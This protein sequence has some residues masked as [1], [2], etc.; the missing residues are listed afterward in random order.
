MAPQQQQN[1]TPLADVNEAHQCMSTYMAFTMG[2]IPATQ[3][4]AQRAGLPFGV[5]VHPLAEG[6]GTMRGN[7]PIVDFGTA[8]VIRCKKCRAYINPFAKFVDGGKRW[9]CNLCTYV[10]D[11]PPQYFQPTDGDGNRI[12]VAQRPELSTG[13]VEFIAPAEYTVRAPQ[14]PVYVFVLDVSWAAISNGVLAAACQTIKANLDQLPGGERTQVGFITFDSAVHFFSLRSGLRAPQMLVVSDVDELFLPIPDELLVNLH[15]GRALVD[16]LLDALPNMFP[17]NRGP[18]SCLGPALQAAYNIMQHIGGKMLVFQSTLPSHGAGKLK[19]RELPKMVGS[20]KEHVL[21]AP[22][23]GEDGNFYRTKAADFSRQQIS[24]DMFLFSHAYT[25]VA[26]LG[27]LSR[28]T[29]GQVYH[30]PGFTSGSDGERF[31]RDLARNLTRTTGFEAVMR[32]RTS[33]GLNVT[34]FYGNFFIRGTDLLALPNVTADTAFN[35]ELVHEEALQPG[36]VITIQAALLYTTST[37]ERRICV[38]TLAKPVTTSMSDLFRGL[39]VHTVT[40]MMAK[41]ALDQ[42]LRTGIPMARRHLHKTVVD[43][44]R[45]YRL[46][47]SGNP[48]PASL[49]AAAG[50]N[51]SHMPS[52]THHMSAPGQTASSSDLSTM[53]PECLQLL[54]LYSMGL[55]KCTL[56]RGGESI[57]SDERAALVYRMLTM[58][59]V[60][61]KLYTHP[62]MYSLHDMDDSA[63]RPDPNMVMN[64][65]QRGASPEA[66]RALPV[67]MPAMVN[68]T[69]ERLVPDGVLLLDNGVE[70]L[71]WVGRSAPP[72]LLQAL[73]GVPSLDQYDFSKPLLEQNNDYSF[74]V[75]AIL[76]TLREPWSQAQ[77]LRIVRDGSNSA[78]EARFH[79]H[80]IEDRQNFPGGTVS[81]TEYLPIVLRE[82]SA[83]QL[84]GTS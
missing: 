71:M 76:R 5:C 38:H 55:Q 9:R 60:F 19:P 1:A 79:F 72:P 42:A 31:K 73:F 83:Q 37:G 47:L 41:T 11:V 77:K 49:T 52:A 2:A 64:M 14:P 15:D 74:R 65:Q 7:I 68:L 69:A 36:T 84:G 80:L 63:G 13:S 35:V 4:M 29:S 17:N 8:G 58:P 44:I 75:H 34:N 54:P 16:R 59:T 51:R 39:D 6:D 48:N 3:Q 30:Y 40:N 67:R 43:V 62:G 81:Y 10:N 18:E 57:R 50:Y 45:G 21:L 46:A 24:V 25:D 26:T 66:I 82:S 23:A 32:V 12:D 27:A 20:D 56:Y 61:S 33:K 53:L 22:D 78:D 70:L 28:Y